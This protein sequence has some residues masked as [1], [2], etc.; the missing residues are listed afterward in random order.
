M[1]NRRTSIVRY[2]PIVCEISVY[3]NVGIDST[4]KGRISMRTDTS[5]RKFYLSPL[6]FTFILPFL[7][8]FPELRV[9]ERGFS[10]RLPAKIAWVGRIFSVS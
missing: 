4:E 2:Q 7:V 3:F 6:I 9:G 1:T 8:E 5:L 10:A